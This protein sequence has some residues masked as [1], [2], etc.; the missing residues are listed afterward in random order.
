VRNITLFMFGGVSNIQQEPESPTSEF[1]MALVGPLTSIVVGAALTLGGSLTSG[2]LAHTVRNPQQVLSGIGP[3]PTLLLWLGSVNLTVGLFNLLP[4]FPLDGGRI[5]RSILWALSDSLRRATRWAAA[6]GQ[7]I[8]WTVIFAGISTV[9]GLR[10][11]FVG[12]GFVNGLWLVFIGW[13]LSDAAAASYRRVVIRDVLEGIPVRRMMRRDPPTVV[14]DVSVST[15][16]QDYLMVLDDQSFPVMR[17]HELVGIVTI[18]DVREIPRER[19]DSATVQA[20]M[21]SVD[22]VVSVAPD[23][24]AADALAR[25]MQRDVRQLPV[26]AGSRLQGLLRRRDIIRWLQF[27]SSAA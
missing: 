18:H 19:W 26:V 27:Q 25:L 11:P 16:V 5:L 20:I 4:A 8:S 23:D 3:L 7:A 6:V 1:L 17:D 12:G 22:N 13:F 14:P 24:D 9:F 2:P 15:L 21:T 10:L